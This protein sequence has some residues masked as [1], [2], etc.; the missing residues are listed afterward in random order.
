[1]VQTSSWRAARDCACETAQPDGR[2]A[3]N[4]GTHPGESMITSP[5]AN[6]TVRVLHFVTGG[7]SGAT[8]VAVELTRHGGEAVGLHSMLVLRRKRQ[9][10]LQRIE[11]LRREGL[12]VCTVTGLA[13]WLSIW[14]LRAICLAYKPDVLVAH[15]FPEHII[16]RW[17]GWLAGVPTLIHVEHNSR[18]RYSWLKLL[19]ARWLAKR[20]KAIIGVSEGVKHSLLALGFPRQRVVAIPNGIDVSRFDHAAG[21]PWASRKADI[22]MCARFSSQKDHCTAIEAMALLKAQGCQSRLVFAGDGKSRYRRQAESLVDRLGLTREVLFLGRSADVP[23]LLSEHRVFLLST[24]YEG[25]PLA[26]LEGMA[27]GCTPVASRVVG[28]R[29]LIVD[30]VDGL[31]VNESDPQ[32]LAAALMRALGVQEGESMAHRASQ[33]VRANH[34]TTQMLTRYSELFRAAGR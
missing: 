4:P 11:D 25:M 32:D 16:G 34:R 8:S 19:Q 9:T 33:K 22:V 1:M 2:A 27:A 29:E 12:N 15:G 14:Q 18:E 24:H 5:S 17:A 30:G 7:F 3:Y 21:V 6:S 31:L 23:A 26:L 13:H 20:T 10:P 28:V